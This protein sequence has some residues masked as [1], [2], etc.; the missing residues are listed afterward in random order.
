MKIGFC[1]FLVLLIST[2]AFAGEISENPFAGKWCGKWDNTYEL[3]ITIND[4]KNHSVADYQ[5]KEQVRGSFQSTTKRIIQFD[6]YTLKL[7][8]IWF[9]LDKNDHNKAKATGMFSQTRHA[10]LTKQS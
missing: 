9:T 4:S 1:L 3:C 5:W 10:E 8:N 6:Q 2:P 7:E